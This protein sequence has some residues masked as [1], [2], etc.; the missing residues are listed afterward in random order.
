VA[1]LHSNESIDT[2]LS[3]K[4]KEKGVYRENTYEESH[5]E[6]VSHMEPNSWN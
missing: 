2:T 6:A 5:S 3:K 4:Q 1:D